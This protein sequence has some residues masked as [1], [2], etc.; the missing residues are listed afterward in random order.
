MGLLSWNTDTGSLQKPLILCTML[1]AFAL[2]PQSLALGH[3][4]CP[5]KPSGLCDMRREEDGKDQEDQSRVDK[6]RGTGLRGGDRSERGSFK[7]ETEC[8]FAGA[9]QNNLRPPPGP[10]TKALQL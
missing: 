5:A 9:Q 4:P 8:T 10:I 2:R 1:S 7:R 3:S 6:S